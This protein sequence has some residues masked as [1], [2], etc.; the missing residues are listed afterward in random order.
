MCM[1]SMPLPLDEVRTKA[2]K[3]C[4]HCNKSMEYLLQYTKEILVCP[5]AIDNKCNNLRPN[6]DDPINK[7][8]CMDSESIYRYEDETTYNC[9]HCDRSFIINEKGAKQ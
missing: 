8:Y 1:K 6:F 3:I 7:E 9:P 4:P 2:K 5:F